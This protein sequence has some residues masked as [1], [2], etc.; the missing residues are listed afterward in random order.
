MQAAGAD[1]VARSW[2]SGRIETNDK[3][4]RY[5]LISGVL[6]GAAA[7]GVVGLV[8]YALWPDAEPEV[9]GLIN[10]LTGGGTLPA[11]ALAK[12]VVGGS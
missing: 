3:I 10:G 1:A 2:K 4:E 9:V 11:G 12:R 5:N 7:A 8:T 6:F